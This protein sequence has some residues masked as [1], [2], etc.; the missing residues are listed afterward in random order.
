LRRLSIAVFVLVLL[1]SFF[2]L[3]LYPRLRAQPRTQPLVFSHAAHFEEATCEACHLYVMEQYDAGVPRLSDC[4]DC[5]EGTQS[6]DPA[7]IKEEAK[8]NKEFVKPDHEIPWELLPQLPSHVFFS[9]RRHVVA[10]KIKCEACHGNIA[11]TKA[12]PGRPPHDFTMNW[13]LDC[14]VTKKASTDCLSCHR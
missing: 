12:I 13:C 3:E 8:F 2:Y 1:G 11:K 7:G 9:H 6:E 4:V 5:H 10:S 14:H